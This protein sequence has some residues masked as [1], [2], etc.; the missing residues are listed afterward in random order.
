MVE[1]IVSPNSFDIT[2]ATRVLNSAAVGASSLARQERA[3]RS[4]LQKKIEVVNERTSRPR[5][6]NEDLSKII[7][8]LSNTVD[9]IKSIRQL[10][11]GLFAE[12]LQADRFK[13]GDN[14]VQFDVKLAQL[15]QVAGQT[16]DTPNLLNSSTD[17]EFV[18]LKTEDG[19]VVTLSGTALGSDYVITETKGALTQGSFTNGGIV[20]PKNGNIT[21]SDHEAR[22]LRRQDPLRDLFTAPLTGNNSVITRDVKLDSIDEF[23]AN[24]VTITFFP[25]TPAA[26]TVTGTLTRSGI[27]VLDSFLYDGFTTAAGRN[28]A[29]EDLEKA[30]GIIDAELVRFEGALKSA[31]L[32]SGQRDLSLASFVSL[33][34]SSTS[35]SVIELHAADNA[36]AFKNN[37]DAKLSSGVESARNQLAKVLGGLNL[38]PP[39]NSVVDIQA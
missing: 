33:L 34:D 23:D 38:S 30:K 39:T 37:F 2:N 36:Q 15:S 17:D 18:F 26:S 31:R 35:A 1:S 25:G 21:F 22:V 11:D 3:I 32:I 13:S 14:A 29:F 28:R 10:A 5:E 4:G 6:S 24:T 16:V 7:S 9:R 27:G 19:R 20:Y 12:V 8:F